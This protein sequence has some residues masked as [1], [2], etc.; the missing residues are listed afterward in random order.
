MKTERIRIGTCIV[1]AVIAIAGSSQAAVVTIV[2]HR[3]DL[4]GNN[5]RTNRGRIAMKSAGPVVALG[6]FYTETDSQYYITEDL[7]SWAVRSAPWATGGGTSADLTVDSSDNY[8]FVY[9]RKVTEPVYVEHTGNRIGLGDGT[10]WSDGAGSVQIVANNDGVSIGWHPRTDSSGGDG[11]Q[12]EYWYRTRSGGSWSATTVLDHTSHNMSPRFLA[13]ADD[14]YYFSLPRSGA[15]PGPF[16]QQADDGSDNPQT[17]HSGLTT[18][19]KGWDNLYDFW[20]APAWNGSA[21]NL[22]SVE[23]DGASETGSGL[24][25]LYLDIQ[26]TLSQ[27]IVYDDS[28]DHGGVST[29]GSVALAAVGGFN[30]VFFTAEDPAVD[31]S[32]DPNAILATTDDEVFVQMVAQDGTLMD[33]AQ[34]LT[35]DIFNQY[36]MDVAIASDGSMHLVYTTQTDRAGA[37]DAGERVSYMKVTPAFDPQ[38]CQEAKALGFDIASDL[39][40][41][42]YVNIGDF[43]VL[44]SEWLDCMDPCDVSCARPWE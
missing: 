4:W 16:W 19:V 7:N 39:N 28:A 38:S 32:G 14:H 25:S 30:Y 27:V 5:N 15:D 37:D 35:F 20:L 33:S 43:G 31:T 21:M 6:T 13:S 22:A 17:L 1:V 18:G 10:T 29:A 24:V 34:Q 26:G 3:P 23:L 8:H 36:E 2:D 11:W 42:C 9:A 40:D 44:A 41:D 12:S